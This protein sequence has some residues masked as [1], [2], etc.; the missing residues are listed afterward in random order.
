M[1]ATG[2]LTIWAWAAPLAS[3]IASVLAWTVWCDT[4]RGTWLGG[5]LIAL[6]GVLVYALALEALPR[7]RHGI[8]A[9]LRRSVVA[10]A[11][12]LIAGMMTFVVAGIGYYVTCRPFG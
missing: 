12:G 8:F 2:R 3:A 4:E 1:W 10:I 7:D 11:L 6:T 5:V 9:T